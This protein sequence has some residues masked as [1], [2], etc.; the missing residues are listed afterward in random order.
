VLVKND[1]NITVGLI[2][3][4]VGGTS[5]DEWKPGSMLY[6]QAVGR[7]REAMKS[8][9]LAGILWHQGEADSAVGKVATYGKRF[10]TMIGQLRSDLAAPDAPVV[11]GELGRFR[12]VSLG[13]N[14]SLPKAVALVPNC[15]LATAENLTDKGDK[16]HFDTKSLHLFGQRY[17]AA[18]LELE[19][20]EKRLSK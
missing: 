5:M 11:L 20:K 7:A 3:C 19:A 14:E 18:F 2:P 12:E 10:S 9:A 6:N 17:A 8:G 15:A 4:A 16:L 13:F 1:T